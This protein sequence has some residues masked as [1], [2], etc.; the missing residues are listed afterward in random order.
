MVH[1]VSLPLQMCARCMQ[2]MQCPRGCV[3][4]NCWLLL[5][6]QRHDALRVSYVVRECV[7]V[8]TC[9]DLLSH[10][11]SVSLCTRVVMLCWRACQLSFTHLFVVATMSPTARPSLTC[12]WPP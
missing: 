11:G 10:G 12:L 7:A 3:L 6:V 1:L 5:L 8:R 9:S 4:H 2:F